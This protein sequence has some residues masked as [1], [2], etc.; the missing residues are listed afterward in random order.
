MFLD[1]R[2]KP[3]VQQTLAGTVLICIIAAFLLSLVLSFYT[4]QTALSESE[5]TL[6]T[7]ID[8]VSR[9]LEYA[10]ESMKHNAR[11][12]L[13]NFMHG[14]PPPR[15]TGRRVEL[16][17]ATRPEIVLSDHIPGIH[18]QA[19]LLAYKERNP[20]ADMA[21]LLQDGGNLYRASTLL[22]DAN[23]RYRD[24]E[25][26]VDAYAKTVLEGKL[27]LGTIQRSGKM[28]AL[29]VKPLKDSASNVIGAI[30]L[31]VPITNDVNILRERLKS[32]VVGK[33]GYLFIIEQ[34]SGDSKDVRFILH[35]T[36]QDK[37]VSE[38]EESSRQIISDIQEQKKGFLPYTWK[39]ANGDSTDRLVA[40]A[41]IPALHWIVAAAVPKSEFTAPYDHIRYLLLLGLAVTVILLIGCLTLLVRWQV[42]PMRGVADGMAYMGQG[43]LTH[44]VVV[45]A[46]SRNEIDRLAVRIN[47]TRNAM[48]D[49]IG[50]IRGTVEKVGALSV[51]S[52]DA[53]RQLAR[54]IDGLSASSGEMS[55]KIGELSTAID[56]I[57]ASADDAHQYVSDAVEKVENGRAV[58]GNVIDSIHLIETRVASTLNEVETLTGHSRQISKV[59]ETIGAIAGQTNLLALNAAIEAARAGEVGRGFAVVADEVRKLAEQSAQSASEIDDILNL[60]TT[61]VTAVRVSIDDVVQETRRSTESSNAAGAA[62]Q[63]IDDITRD[64]AASVTTIADATRKQVSAT[65]V[66]REQVDSSVQA[67][68][69]ANQITREISQSA[70]KLQGEAERLGQDVSRFII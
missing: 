12:E 20:Q 54:S 66:M 34:P 69:D 67:T 38:V 7:Q 41:E 65:Q 40:F 25:I 6:K 28:Y 47:D 27:Y 18:N 61:G 17:G 26:I 30:S 62:L 57:A 16:G 64:I 46:D 35:P 14:L 3:L 10:E 42:R 32:V 31:R 19:F 52:A 13:E 9:T 29:A 53:M 21:V 15:L 8:L 11:T 45:N 68:S 58:V 4:E 2:C 49:L 48:H 50:K 43:D 5:A 70:G 44:D 33:T 56:H 22:K 24:G 39:D 37:L 23:G 55:A 60:I 63:A 36:M 1:I 51:D 59:V